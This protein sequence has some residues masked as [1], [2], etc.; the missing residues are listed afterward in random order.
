MKDKYFGY[1][2]LITSDIYYFNVN[3]KD[4]VYNIEY[5]DSLLIQN[6][7]ISSVLLYSG[8]KGI[9]LSDME[10][11][12]GIPIKYDKHVVD[13]FDEEIKNIYI[14]NNINTLYC[15]IDVKLEKTPKNCE[16]HYFRII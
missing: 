16:I 2:S 15:N 1:Y 3:N 6:K 8:T 4:N 7:K 14:P 12:R 10:M 9:F 13:C 5:S 11:L